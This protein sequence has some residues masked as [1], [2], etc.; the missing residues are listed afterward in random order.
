[1]A[2]AKGVG[3]GVGD[4]LGVKVGIRVT[5]E[6]EVGVAGGRVGVDDSCGVTVGDGSAVKPPV[7]SDTAVTEGSGL[8]SRLWSAVRVV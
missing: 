5:V 8:L 7:V 4:G 2:P 6:V 3:L 1:M